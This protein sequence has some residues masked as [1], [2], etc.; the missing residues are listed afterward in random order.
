MNT[1]SPSDPALLAAPA[2]QFYVSVRPANCEDPSFMA[3]AAKGEAGGV[4]A[5]WSD[6]EGGD[7]GGREIGEA[8]AMERQSFSLPLRS[9]ERVA[10]GGGG[11]R[12]LVHR[13]AHSALKR[14][15]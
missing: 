7:G 9:L 10:A 2:H 14:V 5:R 6:A 1:H 4:E 13:E 3:S 12:I 8:T 11:G 15:R